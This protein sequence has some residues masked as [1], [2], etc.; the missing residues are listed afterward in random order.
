MVFLPFRSGNQYAELYLSIA[1]VR[2]NA[3]QIIL[4]LFQMMLLL[5][6]VPVLLLLPGI[7]SI[8]VLAGCW[9]LI[10]ALTKPIQ[11]PK[12][13]YSK[14]DEKAM[15]SAKQYE[16]ERWLFVNGIATGYGVTFSQ[17]ILSAYV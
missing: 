11:G 4:F 14:M 16:H 7:L 8:M 2:D 15:E 5:G 13:V 3:L 10:L 1:N 9:L 6:S 12:V 17:A